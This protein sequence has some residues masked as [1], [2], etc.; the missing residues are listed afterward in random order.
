MATKEILSQDEVEALREGVESGD[1]DTDSP[2][3]AA[4]G[5]I[6]PYDLTSQ[7]RSVRIR[8]PALDLLNERL[9]RLLSVSLPNMLRC[10][11]EVSSQGIRTI[12][13]AD[14]ANSLSSPIS[15]NL[16]RIKPLRGVALIVLDSKFVFSAIE[17]FFGADGRFDTRIEEREFTAVELRLVRL[18]L[19]SAFADLREAWKPIT[20]VDFEY[21]DSEANPQ[22]TNIAG[23]NDPVVISSFQI[24]FEK[25]AGELHV[26]MPYGML[27]PLRDVLAVGV[28]SDSQEVDQR[29]TA[30]LREEVKDAVVGVSSSLAQ[31]KITLREL[32]RLSAGDVIPIDLPATVTAIVE[33]VPVFHC[34]YGVSRGCNAVQ[35]ASRIQRPNRED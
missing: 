33:G 4:D 17:A 22:F 9:A 30:S 2:V 14:Y 25:C 19:Q 12:K 23:P 1:I 8:M 11:C 27:E 26:T 3:S 18:I 6:R 34:H 5:E 16:V 35:V 29:W 28:S 13:F 31:T 21:V 15:L 7:E 32:M 20:Q 24:E 10:V